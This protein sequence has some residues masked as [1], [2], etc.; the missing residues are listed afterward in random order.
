M[1]GLR[2]RRPRWRVDS[3]RNETSPPRTRGVK[4]AQDND[5]LR[6]P[7]A[8][9]YAS[10]AAKELL[11]ILEVVAQAIP[12]PGVGAAVKIA[13][14]LIRKCDE[15]HAH[16]ERANELKL[17]IMTLVTVLVNELKGKKTEDM[18]EKRF[19]DIHSLARD[20][21]YIQTKLEEIAS[22]RPLL[23]ILFKSYNEEKIG[24]CVDRLNNSLQRFN[25]TRELHHSNILDQLE[26]QI[27]SFHASQQQSLNHIE[28]AVD[29]VKAK[30][31]D[32]KAIL[33][34]RQ[35]ATGCSSRLRSRCLPP[36]NTDIFYGRDTL[37]AELVHIVTN[38][39][40]FEGQKRPQICI[41]GPGG[42]GKTTTALAVMAHSDTKRH[43][44]DSLVWVPCVK[45]T[46]TA[47]FL[48]TL[49]WSLGVTPNTEMLEMTSLQ[50]FDRP[51]PWF[52]SLT[53][54][55]HPGTSME[56]GLIQS[57]YSATSI[58]YHISP[59]LSP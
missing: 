16:S 59:F 40:D 30:M 51:S 15:S 46:S 49:Y 55:K 32:I 11:N 42:M 34:E 7:T 41:L 53:I 25:L 22:Q 26:K 48:D 18:Q 19:Q 57:G 4:Q 21:R 1:S 37:V 13:A 38:D 2:L 5:D 9:E 31:D 52:F 8:R 54:S 23:L 29:D 12:I 56:H 14:N 35:S 39:S 6:K 20:L 44:P 33:N 10:E 17:S 47:L 3:Q 58:R 24:K 36:A 43:F 27:R 28:T 50:N 45:A